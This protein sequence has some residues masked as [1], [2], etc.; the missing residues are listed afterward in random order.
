L[1]PHS[2]SC[3]EEYMVHMVLKIGYP[4]HST[5]FSKHVPC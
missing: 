1:I 5:G 2:I 3:L 4:I